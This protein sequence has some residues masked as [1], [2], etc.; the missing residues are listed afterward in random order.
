MNERRRYPTAGFP[1]SFR[2]SDLDSQVQ[3]DLVN[4]SAE[5]GGTSKGVLYWKGARVPKTAVMLMHPRTDQTQNYT[6]PFLVEAGFAAYGQASRWVNN[7]IATIHETLL[8]DAGAGVRYLKEQR[9]FSHVVFIGNSGGGS[10]LS[11]YQ[12]R[13]ATPPPSRLT[14]TPAGDPPDL[15]RYALIPG[16]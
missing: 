2:L 9:G 15:N 10:L 16:D 14:A 6:I 13:A 8:L 3:R 7:D 11:L 4:L 1:S 5:D 12:S